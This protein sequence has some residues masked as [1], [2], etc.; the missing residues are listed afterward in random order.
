LFFIN[1]YVIANY[2][3][4][5]NQRRGPRASQIKEKPKASQIKEGSKG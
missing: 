5:I 3:G 4:I 2:K 1:L